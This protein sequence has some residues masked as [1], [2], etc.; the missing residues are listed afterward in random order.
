[1][2]A[3]ARLIVL[4]ALAPAMAQPAAGGLRYAADSRDAQPVDDQRPE[5]PPFPAE[6]NLVKVQ[7]DGLASFELFVDLESVSVGTDGV[8]RYTVVARTEGGASNITYEGL[9]CRERERML[10]AFGRADGTW[11]LARDPKWVSVSDLLANRIQATLSDAY[12]CR[13]RLR[14]RDTAEARHRLR[15]GG[16]PRCSGS[17]RSGPDCPGG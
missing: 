4:L 16:D 13:A 1:M 17:A 12:F 6:K 14:V 11:S 15:Q 7:V 3:C 2:N 5:L 10:Y 8:V 9:R